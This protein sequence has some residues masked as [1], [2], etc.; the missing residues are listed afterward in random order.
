M[1]IGGKNFLEKS[2][3]ILGWQALKWNYFGNLVRSVSQFAIGIILARMLGPEPF[4][5]V[6]VAWLIL[7]LGNLFADMGLGSALVQRVS[8]SDLDLRLIFTWQMLFASFL[9]GFGILWAEHI[10]AY[11]HK[12]DA[13]P[14]IQ[15]MF[16]LFVLQSLGQTAVA[17]LRRSLNFKTLHQITVTSYLVGYLLVGIPF[18]Y[19]GLGVWS[20]VVA[21]LVQSLLNSIL[22]IR[23][24]AVPILP[25]FNRGA[26]DLLKFGLKVT[27]AN[28]SSW[29]I[30]NLDTVFIGR[31]FGV[32]DL[33]L[34]NRAMNLLNAPMSIITTGFQGVLFSACAR[35]QSDSEK[36]KRI[37]LETT[38]AVAFICFP[39]F[40]T[41]AAVPETIIFGIYGHKWQASVPVV[42]PLSLAILINALLAVNGPI[43]MAANRIGVELKNQ[44]Y[45]ILM[46]IPILLLATKYS[47]AA[48]AWAVLAIYAVRWI[49]LTIATSHVT[50]VKVSD[51]VVTCRTP[52]LFA[53]GISAAATVADNY[54]SFLPAFYKLLAVISIACI[55]MLILMRIF[56]G[57][58]L[59]KNLGTL[60][61]VKNLHGVLR[62]FLNV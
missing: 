55:A 34:Y 60:V 13:T 16:F 40:V 19:M 10:A 3:P 59:R 57:Y 35:T 49:L 28:I 36:I 37:Y 7:G 1:K 6:A 47:L 9:T 41:A 30:S 27:A 50:G 54:L 51:Y 43:L 62:N 29:C 23:V 11:F 52:V 38:A 45:T 14:V 44:F 46:S 42:M 4:G 17:V 48:V 2:K 25:F 39:I 21:Q 26:P 5:I 61:E 12:P 24:T 33:G 58:F 8:L 53:C 20:L 32:V 56:G 31:A 18:A 22:L 15:V